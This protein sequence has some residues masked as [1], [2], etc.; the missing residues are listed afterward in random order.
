MAD[1]PQNPKGGEPEGDEPKGGEPQDPKGGGT[2]QLPKGD[3]GEP[4]GGEPSSGNPFLNSDGTLKKGF[5]EHL[6]EHLQGNKS[7]DKFKDISSVFQSY[8]NLEERLGKKGVTIPDEN[9][10][11]EEWDQFK[12]ALN[13]PSDPQNVELPDPENMPDGFQQDEK[14][15]EQFKEAM[16]EAGI[17]ESAAK[18]L[19]QRFHDWADERYQQMNQQTEEA[20]TRARDELRQEWGR[21]YDHNVEAARRAAESLGV[22]EQLDQSGY[23]N[24]PLILRTLK[25]AF[26]AIGEDT[27]G[28]PGGPTPQ[29]AAGQ[30]QQIRSDPNHPYN[31]P[32]SPQHA[33]AVK[34][35]QRLYQQAYT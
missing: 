31:N 25:G 33:D 12:E 10:S 34:Q 9:S 1:D 6:P 24:D 3:G 15:V 7:L 29:D 13:I 32:E 27:L 19:W 8:A 22:L 4:K 16:V 30:I 28:T 11:Q 26:D 20:K 18:T 5:K 14:F 2:P 17:P 21:Q 35:V 23:G